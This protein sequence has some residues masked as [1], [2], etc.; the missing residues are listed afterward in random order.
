MPHL[1][2]RQIFKQALRCIVEKILDDGATL[3]D[4]FSLVWG[5][6]SWSRNVERGID[7][8]DGE[9]LTLARFGDGTT[10]LR[11][12]DQAFSEIGIRIVRF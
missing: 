8:Y 3:A 6:E 1:N 4:G 12:L 11:T 5:L 10:I 7:R 2:H 9:H